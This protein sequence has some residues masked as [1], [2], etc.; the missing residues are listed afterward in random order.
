MVSQAAAYYAGLYSVPGRVLSCAGIT[1]F[2]NNRC[3]LAEARYYAENPLW[4]Q[5]SNIYGFTVWL[6]KTLEE[7]RYNKVEYSP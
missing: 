7:L 3:R 6:R 1:V 4:F 2:C 5:Y